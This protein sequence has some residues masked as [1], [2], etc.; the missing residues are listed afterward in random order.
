MIANSI[1]G[2]IQ[3]ATP[4]PL[5]R[6]LAPLMNTNKMLK[7]RLAAAKTLEEKTRIQKAI[8]DNK[9][10]IAQIKAKNI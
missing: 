2:L 9:L 7:T 10:K 5:E 4:I 1:I 6:I 8:L 3:E